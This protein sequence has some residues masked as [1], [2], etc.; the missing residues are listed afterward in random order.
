VFLAGGGVHAEAYAPLLRPIAARGY[1]VFVVRLPYRIAPLEGHKVQAIER[2]GA[3]LEREPSASRWVVG[4][5][6]LGAALACRLAARRPRRIAG[7]VLIGT[8][9]PR[10]AD[11]SRLP[12]PVTKVYASN[13]GIAPEE[14]VETN[15]RL[16]PAHTRWVRIAG[17]NHAQFGHYGRQL[18]DGRA[19]VTRDEQQRVTREALLETLAA[20]SRAAGP[21]GGALTAASSPA[22]APGGPGIR[23]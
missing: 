22:P 13:D 5:H 4:G 17:G 10:E 1:P 20:V 14:A 19:D 12:T 6:S 21:D 15:R 8:T 18:F 7:L 3:I 2:A 9:H 11:L 23:R 16:L